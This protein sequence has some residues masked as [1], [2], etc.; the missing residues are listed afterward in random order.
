MEPED[1]TN[2]GSLGHRLQRLRKSCGL[3]QQSVAEALGVARTTVVGFEQGRR[4][5]RAEELV[6]LA[7]LYG[8]TVSDLVRI[9]PEP[10]GGE[11]DF[12]TQLQFR[13][14]A[15]W[16]TFTHELPAVAERLQQLAE[17]YRYVEHL[18]DAVV[19]NRA[20]PTYT[21]DTDPVR[22]GEDAA[23]AER[24]RLN[25]GD[26]PLAGVRGL[27]AADLGLRVFVIDLPSKIAGMYAHD[28]RLGDCVAI[29]AR[30][31]P[32]R[33]RWSMVHEA[34]HALHH[35]GAPQITL[36][37]RQRSSKEE[38]FAE[39]FACTFLMPTTGLRRRFGELRKGRAPTA[40]DIVGLSHLYGVSFEAMC[41]RL[42]DVRCLA[43]GTWE[44]L[45]DRGFKPHE[46]ARVLEL[47][48][49]PP[50]AMLP[51]R[52]V[53]LAVG[54]YQRELLSEGQ[55]AR[56]LRVDRV[57]ARTVVEETQTAITVSDSGETLHRSV[58]LT[59]PL[60]AGDSR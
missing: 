40:A 18:L 46:A 37:G 52:F 32:E 25:L 35:R 55:L 21:F 49:V 11:P 15:E 44:L 1:V 50:E 23:V 6:A 38:R 31:P 58:D 30:H 10:D 13:A 54:A 59:Q 26:G 45:R 16:A 47:P 2:G 33:Q 12:A 41:L 24:A 9:L 20:L 7:A 27:L 57:A 22:E 51:R 48:K 42:E 17:D 36:V 28:D 34:G 14:Q 56:L 60:G 29:N 43:P 5:V 39:G 19:P 53:Q 4:A 8:R 3:T